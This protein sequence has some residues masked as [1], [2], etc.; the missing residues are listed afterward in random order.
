MTKFKNILTVVWEWLFVLNFA[1]MQIILYY[2]LKF[3]FAKES[4]W[5]A[6]MKLQRFW[7]G[8]LRVTMGVQTII[9]YEVPLE[10]GAVYIFTPNHTSFL[11]ILVA[12]KFI[13]GYFHFMA[14]STLAKVPLFGIMFSKT[15]IPFERSSSLESSKAF[16]KACADIRKGYCILVYPE[17]TQNSRK[18]TLLPFKSGAFK[19]SV[20]MNIPV[21]PVT[22]L[23]NLEV[24][25]HQSELFKPRSG[26]PGKVYIKVGKPIYPQECDQDH[27]KLSGKVSDIMLNHLHSYYETDKRN[28]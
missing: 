4:R 13:P 27:T 25:P 28:R 2:P 10:P 9:D 11:D 5:S 8:W 19:M 15:H 7:A 3:L 22:C 21:V 6:S 23:N 18:G 26:G 20:K 12:Y 17:G 14:K 1:V 16:D 24:L